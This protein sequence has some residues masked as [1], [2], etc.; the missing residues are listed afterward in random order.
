[1]TTLS[2]RIHVGNQFALAMR[3]LSH[4][5]FATHTFFIPV[6]H[7]SELCSTVFSLI[8]DSWPVRTDSTRELLHFTFPFME[9]HP[10]E[11][12]PQSGVIYI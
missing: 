8:K 10:T 4:Q 11:L 5:I 12:F 1:M 6:T 7:G 9:V 3:N 2:D